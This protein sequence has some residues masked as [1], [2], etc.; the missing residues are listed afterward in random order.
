VVDGVETGKQSPARVEIT[1]GIHTIALRLD[2]YQ[3][4]RRSVQV[5]EGG[6]VTVNEKL[7]VK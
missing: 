1:A 5:T 7:R 3:I 2:G 4:S 6:T